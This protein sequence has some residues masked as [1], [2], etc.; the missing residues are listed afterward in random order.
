MTSPGREYKHAELTEKIIG[1]FYEVY[2]ELGHGSLESVY[3]K[4]L[5]I[6]LREAGLRADEHIA[7]PVYFRGR[8]VGDFDADVL[9][10]AVVPLE[11]KAARAIDPGHEAQLL[12]YLRAT[13]LEVGLLLNFGPHPQVKRMAFA[14]SRKKLPP[15][16][17]QSVGVPS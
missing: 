6:A 9:V 4:A 16:A 10:E 2:N 1:I 12:N 7:A 11:L 15:G 14:N 17:G 13:T 5:V 8:L 3:Q